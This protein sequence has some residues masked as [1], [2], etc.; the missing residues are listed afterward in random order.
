MK[1]FILLMSIFLFGCSVDYDLSNLETETKEGKEKTPAPLDAGGRG[2]YVS[3]T[4][5]APQSC[6]SFM[7]TKTVEISG[8]L[9]TIEI[10]VLCDPARYVEKGRP[11]EN[12]SFNNEHQQDP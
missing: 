7:V 12:P 8:K 5:E 10:P 4:K 1:H 6:D 3:P 9:V 11:V 2:D